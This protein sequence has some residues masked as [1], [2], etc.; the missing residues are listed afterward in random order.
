MPEDE[1]ARICPGGS[2]AW[3]LGFSD[4]IPPCVAEHPGTRFCVRY[5][6]YRIC[7]SHRVDIEFSGFWRAAVHGKL[8]IDALQCPGTAAMCLV[9]D[10]FS[11]AGDLCDSNVLQ[12]GR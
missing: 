8:G 9:A 3:R 5:F 6:W 7:N 1:V 12:P 2:S 10:S 4:D 11:R